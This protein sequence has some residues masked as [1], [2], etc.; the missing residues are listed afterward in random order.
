MDIQ[1]FVK[2]VLVDIDK[3]VEDARRETRRDISF[4][5]TPGQ[6]DSGV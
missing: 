2:S 3:A 4:S 1:E 6:E 5:N